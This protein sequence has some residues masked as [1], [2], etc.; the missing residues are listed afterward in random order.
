MSPKSYEG[1][2]EI[3]RVSSWLLSPQGKSTML[4]ELKQSQARAEELKKA[5]VVTVK[6]LQEPYTI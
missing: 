6:T 5:A 4:N 3:K 1:A 2:A